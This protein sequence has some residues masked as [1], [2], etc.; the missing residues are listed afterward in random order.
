MQGMQRTFTSSFNTQFVLLPL[1]FQQVVVSCQQQ[2]NID[3]IV[4]R[5][6]Y[7]AH[8]TSKEIAIY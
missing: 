7:Q 8:E 6:G 3:I 1:C 5:S 2:Q 4:N